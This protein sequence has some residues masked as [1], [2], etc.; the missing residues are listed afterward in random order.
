MK[1]K[2][3][4][5]FNFLHLS[6]SVIV[7]SNPMYSKESLLKEWAVEKQKADQLKVI[8]LFLLDEVAPSFSITQTAKGYRSARSIYNTEDHSHIYF[9]PF[10]FSTLF[11]C[12]L[13]FST[14]IFSDSSIVYLASVG[15][16]FLCLSIYLSTY[17][18]IY[19][20]IFLSVY[21]SIYI[22]TSLVTEALKNPM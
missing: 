20:S 9:F 21:L 6:I 11:S 15:L 1:L 8:L 18:T 22:P 17:L 2:I 3:S 14:S 13:P 5:V 4:L 16:T 19:L 7:T 10:S 12:M